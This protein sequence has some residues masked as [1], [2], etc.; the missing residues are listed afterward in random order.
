M[1]DRPPPHPD[2]PVPGLWHDWGRAPILALT[3]FLLLA[4]LTVQLLAYGLG[5]GLMLPV[6]AGALLGVV[7]PLEMLRRRGLLAPAADLGLDRP[8]PATLGLVAVVALAGLLPTSLLAEGSLRLHPIDPTWAALTNEHLPR[9]AGGTVLAVLAA[10]VAAPLAEEIVFRAFLQRLAASVWGPWPGLVVA[11][12]AFGLVH[13]EPWYLFGLIGV[14]LVMGLVWEATRSLTACW[15][16]H[17]LHN[18]VSLGAL[19]ASGGIRLEPADYGPGDWGLVAAS[20]VV[21]AVAGGALLRRGR[22]GRAA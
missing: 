16:A 8:R 15:L 13:G 22:T 14:G 3:V 11:A 21:L 17:A 19:L 5:G 9:G 1:N 10:V 12:L 4:N 6:L 18:A 2:G 20:A 7:A